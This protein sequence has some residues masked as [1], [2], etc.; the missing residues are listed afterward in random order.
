M[1]D[2]EESKRLG[3]EDG[4]WRGHFVCGTSGKRAD[5]TRFQNHVTSWLNSTLNLS[6]LCDFEPGTRGLRRAPSRTFTHLLAPPVY[7]ALTLRRGRRRQPGLVGKIAENGVSLG[8]SPSLR[9]RK[10]PP[11]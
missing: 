7:A 5:P 4:V 3:R 10:A 11:V 2:G 1:G 6:V 8:N 9:A